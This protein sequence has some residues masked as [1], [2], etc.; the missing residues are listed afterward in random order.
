MGEESD[1][2]WQAGLVEWGIED[3][4]GLCPIEDP[5]FCLGARCQITGVCDY[6]RRRRVARSNGHQG[7][8]A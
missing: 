8:G 2:D 5:H 3:A 6:N 4:Q 7:G 1:A